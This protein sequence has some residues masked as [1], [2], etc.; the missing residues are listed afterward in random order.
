MARPLV[1]QDQALMGGLQRDAVGQAKFQS[2]RQ[3]QNLDLV[4]DP[5]ALRVRNGYTKISQV[6]SDTTNPQLT[7]VYP[8]TLIDNNG[9]LIEFIF[10]VTAQSDGSGYKVRRFKVGGSTSDDVEIYSSADGD[11]SI[12]NFETVGNRV[13]FS[14]E[15]D[16]E[17]GDHLRWA[18]YN[19]SVSYQAGMVKPNTSPN[20]SAS[21][22]DSRVD[23][24][25]R[26][27]TDSLWTPVLDTHLYA[28]VL[29]VFEVGDDPIVIN[30]MTVWL[31][32]DS[33]NLNTGRIRFRIEGVISATGE[34]NGILLSDDSDTGW[35]DVSGFFGEYLPLT[36]RMNPVLLSANTKYALVIEADQAFQEEQEAVEDDAVDLPNMQT[37]LDNNRAAIY[38]WENSTNEYGETNSNLGPLKRKLCRVHGVTLTATIDNDDTSIVVSDSS[39]IEKNRLNRIA[40]DSSNGQNKIKIGNEIMLITNVNTTSHTLTVLRG[41]DGSTATS[42]SANAPVSAGWETLT[43][44]DSNNTSPNY[45][46]R[47]AH[48]EP[49]NH[50]NYSPDYGGYIGG[51]TGGAVQKDYGI[52]HR[53]ATQGL[54]SSLQVI[55]NVF[56]TGE[57]ADAKGANL[58]S[59]PTLV[60]PATSFGVYRQVVTGESGS[61]V[62]S[63][64]YYKVYD[65]GSSP[66]SFIDFTDDVQLSSGPSLP[67][68]LATSTLPTVADQDGNSIGLKDLTYWNERMWGFKGDTIYFSMRLETESASFGQVGDS[69]PDYFPALN[70]F[71]MNRPI[72]GI[73][74]LRE[75]LVVFHQNSISM[76]TGG[77]SPLNP[78]PDL[79][80]RN[81]LSNEGASS[82]KMVA[83]IDG[84]LF[85]F[86][87]HNELK[88]FSPAG[89]TRE[90][91][92]I[93]Q[94]VFSGITQVVEVVAYKRSIVVGVEI[95]DG[96]SSGRITDLLILDLS[97][98]FPYWK[99]YKYMLSSTS[100][101]YIRG[102]SV[103]DNHL[104]Y[105][106][107]LSSDN[108]FPEHCLV[109][110]SGTTDDGVAIPALAETHEIA[111]GRREQWRKYHLE[112]N[113]SSTVPSV[114]ATA[115]AKDGTTSG[116]TFTATGSNDIRNHH[117]G[118]RILSESCRFKVNWNASGPD[119]LLLLGF[120]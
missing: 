1:L 2:L 5:P 45:S 12:V 26:R 96:S 94:S 50:L 69:L 19:S 3:M 76:L 93:N 85:Y 4:Q 42:H 9:N 48:S 73:K 74:A 53:W 30:L 55:K 28:G 44:S 20:I 68:F 66:S 18:T 83:E 92:D 89:S 59:F 10:Y 88:M 38:C 71:A 116:R 11:P 78:P 33:A 29:Q 79:Q 24:N 115:T 65:L 58:S 102:L 35:L 90:I 34:P 72:T 17:N 113:Y 64:D 103:N 118:L 21:D 99:T 32:I 77:Y 120:E 104:I 86:N 119:E 41:Q 109:L 31:N 87:N 80:M 110:D 36:I 51:Q 97:E 54:E 56:F 117:G 60:S 67:S 49:R 57:N 114:T 52:T 22:P 63:Q 47:F 8:T 25:V 108:S 84:G 111:S 61:G 27:A 43:D 112:F 82:S 39:G 40:I 6:S 7:E 105:A 46:L 37:Y 14:V 70:T 81:I 13:F 15:S 95:G 16:P 75:G 23:N 106:S 62:P 100:P 101:Q 98:Q 107:G 91:S